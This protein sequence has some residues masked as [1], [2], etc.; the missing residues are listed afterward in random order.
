MVHIYNGILLSHQ[1]EWNWVSSSDVDEPRDCHTEWNNLAQVLIK[2]L[3]PSVVLWLAWIFL[4][5]PP[6]YA[7][8]WLVHYLTPPDTQKP[9]WLFIAF[10]VKSKINEHAN[11]PPAGINLPFSTSLYFNL[12]TT[13]WVSSLTLALDLM[14]IHPHPALSSRPEPVLP[15]VWNPQ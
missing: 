7:L 12:Q 9:S 2:C 15:D 10:R 6:N 3:W 1:K 11:L 4:Q 8:T 13:Q 5:A 14:S